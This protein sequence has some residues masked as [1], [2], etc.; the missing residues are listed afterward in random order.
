MKFMH[1]KTGQFK[2]WKPIDV[3]HIKRRGE[4]I[5]SRLFF[6]VLAGVAL[7]IALLNIVGKKDEAPEVKQDI[8]VVETG[9]DG[10]GNIVEEGEVVN[11]QE[12]IV[13]DG[14]ARYIQQYNEID[15]RVESVR[16]YLASRQAPLADYADHFVE[17]AD[18]YGIDYRLVPAISVME[19]NG[20]KH[21]FRDYNAWGWGSVNFTSFE[22]GIETVTRG[23]K[24]G[25]YD[26][27]LDTVA[28]I[29]PVYC[30]PNAKAWTNGVT[31]FMNYMEV[32]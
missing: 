26:A 7:Y 2:M 29:A 31:E 21:L 25:Y 10:A 27:G 14:Q 22:E 24:T 13:E 6:V 8:P 16:T 32:K 18:K 9:V 30:P 23:L 1:F 5:F 17:A 28:E 12:V 19:S 11:G 15:P 3:S 4:E 20:G